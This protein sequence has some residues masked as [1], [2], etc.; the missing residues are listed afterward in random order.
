MEFS[1]FHLCFTQ[2]KL[3][4]PN[5]KRAS[6]SE[7]CSIGSPLNVCYGFIIVVTMESIAW[8]PSPCK[9]FK[10]RVEDF[11]QESKE[12]RK[13]RLEIKKWSVEWD[14]KLRADNVNHLSFKI[15]LLYFQCVKNL[16]YTLISHG[17]RGV[18]SPLQLAP[19]QQSRD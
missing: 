16:N 7:F 18:R 8:T 2:W 9:Y 1:P 12:G 15:L 3:K 11:W 19:F 17:K 10:D 4:S 13:E 5:L 6:I 14:Q